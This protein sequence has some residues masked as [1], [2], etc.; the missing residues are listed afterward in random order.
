M[1]YIYLFKKK[2]MGR[3]QKLKKQRKEEEIKKQ[4]ASEEKSKIFWVT[5]ATI[6]IVVVGG[7]FLNNWYQSN[8]GDNMN[9][10]QV[11]IHTNMGDIKLALYPE[12]APKTV[13][14]F[15]GHAQDGYYDGTLFHRVIQNFMIQGG[16]PLSK[17][18]DPSN[19]GTGG[20]SIWG[21]PFEDEINSKSLGLSDDQI[22]SLEAQGYIYDES[23]SSYNVEPGV[24]AMANSG[25]NT[26]AS[27]FFIVT[28][29]A[30]PHLDGKHTVF[31]KVVEGMDVVRTI[32]A[33]EVNESDRPLENVVI[34]SMEVVEAETVDESSGEDD[35]SD[36]IDLDL[37]NV[38]VVGGDDFSIEFEEK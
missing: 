22:S 16:D 3:A 37:G 17:D 28:E 21:S 12:A 27:Q 15:I 11:V 14:N 23:L 18:D 1:I 10:K 9:N 36:P 7:Y 25:P 35:L 4:Q 33:V 31:G 29:Q 20:E 38:E 30:Q 8:K 13:E 19:D 24:I 6:L 2:K 5:L 26:N 34:N 32:A